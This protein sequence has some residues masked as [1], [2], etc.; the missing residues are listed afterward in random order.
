MTVSLEVDTKQLV[1]ELDEFVNGIKELTKPKVLDNISK[2]VFTITGKRFMIDIDNYSRRNPKKMHHIYEWGKVG[3][4]SARLFVLERSSMINGNLTINT[5]FLQSRM[6]VPIDPKLL[7]PGKTGKRVSSRSV[8][9]NKANIM[10]SGTPVSF[11]AKRVLAF[12][13][14][15]EIAFVAP[16]TQINILHPGGIQTK[17]AFASYMVEWY[18]RN[19]HTVM[20]SSGFYEKISN[21]VAK[22]L[23]TKKGGAAQVRYAVS[24]VTNSI[25]GGVIIK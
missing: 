6:P 25:D 12:M 14:N 11:Q 21:A 13:G 15:N 18:S 19:G 20:D 1:N 7:S 17:N 4:S 8:F 10:E 2:A 23:N 24:E 16:G 22:A 9:R 3:N 5:N